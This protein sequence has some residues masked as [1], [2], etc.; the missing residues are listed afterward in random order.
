MTCNLC[1]MGDFLKAYMN[2]YA[3]QLLH[4]LQLHNYT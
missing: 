3:G 4:K 1:N 2:R